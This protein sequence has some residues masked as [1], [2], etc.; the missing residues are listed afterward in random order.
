MKTTDLFNGI[1][2]PIAVRECWLQVCDG[3]VANHW[4]QRN[5]EIVSFKT[6]DIA[7]FYEVVY[8]VH[9]GKLRYQRKV[10][11]VDSAFGDEAFEFLI[12]LPVLFLVL[13]VL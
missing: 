5:R 7:I 6:A 10:P 1:H 4:V 8:A 2:Q 9:R 3:D 12:C 13:A 11:C